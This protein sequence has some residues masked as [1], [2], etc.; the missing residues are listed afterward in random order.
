MTL[1]GAKAVVKSWANMTQTG[2]ANGPFHSYYAGHDAKHRSKA[3]AYGTS[4]GDMNLS[5][6]EPQGYYQKV[7]AKTV[8][9][10][11]GVE[12]KSV[13]GKVPTPTPVLEPRIH[14]SEGDLSKDDEAALLLTAVKA[15]AA[16]KGHP[17]YWADTKGRD[18]VFRL[19]CDIPQGYRGG[20]F[21]G[22]GRQFPK[23]PSGCDGMVLVISGGGGSHLITH[24]PVVQSTLQ[25]TRL[26]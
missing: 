8:L 17:A 24:Y 15:A 7:L 19:T 2:F 12:M 3:E 18:S 6:D 26:S 16:D 5:G 21:Q 22:G 23:A 11:T 14:T 25:G 20:T 10:Q 9:V 13:W 1:S 4:H